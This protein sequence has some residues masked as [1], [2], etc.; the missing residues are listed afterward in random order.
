MEKSEQLPVLIIKLYTSCGFTYGDPAVAELY[1]GTVAGLILQL[2]L[3]LITC[4]GWRSYRQTLPTDTWWG[5]LL[6]WNT[7]LGVTVWQMLKCQWWLVEV[8]CVLSATRV[9]CTCLS[10]NQCVC[11]HNIRVSV[12]CLNSN[13]KELFVWKLTSTLIFLNSFVT[14][15]VE[16]CLFLVS[17]FLPYCC[18]GIHLKFLGFVFPCLSVLCL[19]PCICLVMNL[20]MLWKDLIWLLHE[21]FHSQFLLQFTNTSILTCKVVSHCYN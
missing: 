5:F 15:T 10:Q 17:D 13:F 16:R 2:D 20:R 9:P 7:S 19:I 3:W 11:I 8:G 21:T 4:Y 14:L 18:T 12:R 6:C 1:C